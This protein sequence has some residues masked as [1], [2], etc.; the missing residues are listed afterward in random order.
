M[1]IKLLEKYPYQSNL[2]KH[3]Q[4][5]RYQQTD[6]GVNSCGAHVL[7]RLYRLKTQYMDLD[8]YHNFMLQLKDDFNTSYDVVVAEF[9]QPF[10]QK[11]ILI[12][13]LMCKLKLLSFSHQAAL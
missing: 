8:A 6:I 4:T 12:H 5:V 1:R 7:H 10:F 13:T 2:L 11:R 9:V 3:V